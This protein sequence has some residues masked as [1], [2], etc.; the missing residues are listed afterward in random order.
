MTIKGIGD[1][2]SSAIASIS[3]NQR[4]AAVDGNVIRVF[5]R[6]RAVPLEAKD[7]LLQK[8]AVA[9]AQDL[10]KECDRPGDFNQSMMELGAMICTPKKPKCNYSPVRFACKA[11]A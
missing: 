4:D 8:R 7:K 3:F 9:F 5:S 1:Y 10:I 11:D 6:V 2:T